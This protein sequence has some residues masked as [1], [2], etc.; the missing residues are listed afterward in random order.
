MTSTHTG[1][2]LC[3]AAALASVKKIL[4]TGLVENARVTG[5]LLHKKL[6]GIAEQHCGIVGGLHGRG[7]VAGL[8]IV[9]RNSLQPDGDLAFLIVEKAYQRG[10]LLFAPVGFGGATVKICP[11]LTITEDAILDGILALAE[12]IDEASVELARE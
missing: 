5:E 1:N 4:E 12:A 8:H 10:L 3:V 6:A 2:P 7:L 11:P 9:R